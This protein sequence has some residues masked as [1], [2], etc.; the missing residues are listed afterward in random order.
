MSSR[1]GS[2]YAD[3][4]EYYK[5]R[6]HI[7]CLPLRSLWN[8]IIENWDYG[9]CDGNFNISKGL[10][11]FTVPAVQAIH[12]ITPIDRINNTREGPYHTWGTIEYCTETKKHY[13][14]S[15]KSGQDSES[16]SQSL[17]ASFKAGSRCNPGWWNAR[18]I[19]IQ[20]AIGRCGNGHLIISTL[21]TVG[22]ANTMIESWLFPPIRATDQKSISWFYRKWFPKL[23]P[24]GDG[25]LIPAF[26][27]LKV[28][29]C[30]YD[31]SRIEKSPNRF[32]Y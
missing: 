13:F 1:F 12:N 19:T 4:C 28:Q 23:I 16:L 22:T 11:L 18:H 15:R 9:I 26:E 31:D 29:C 24:T 20:T 10:V 21:H 3:S 8:P 32:I 2:D 5:Q 14:A 30:P 25:S 17:R 27:V 7:I 6:G